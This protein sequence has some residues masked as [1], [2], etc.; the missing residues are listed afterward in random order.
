[1]HCRDHDLERLVLD[2]L[3]S[4]V[5]MW[6]VT[7]PAVEYYSY[8]VD[9]GYILF[10]LPKIVPHLESVNYGISKVVFTFDDI[11]QYVV[12]VPFRSLRPYD[13]S[14]NAM[15]EQVL[16]SDYCER[17]AEIYIKAQGAH[18]DEMLCGTWHI[19][20]VDDDYDVYLSERADTDYEYETM[21]EQTESSES[22]IFMNSLVSSNSRL[23]FDLDMD[24]V[25]EFIDCYG[26]DKV[27]R[28][29][30]FISDNKI[31]DLHDGNVMWVGEKLKLVDYS[32][33]DEDLW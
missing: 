29:L 13:T 9:D 10:E 25:E 18:V 14:M 28:L 2:R 20:K 12:K 32:S 22:H 24:T 33:F 11:D 30:K 19:G 26:G 1:M 17:E 7:H 31:N 23:Y 15:A 6:R 21:Y 27:E 5:D 4:K 8:D 16:K 3:Q